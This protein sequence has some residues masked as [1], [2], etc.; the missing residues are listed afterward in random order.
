MIAAEYFG[1]DR[2]ISA[3]NGRKPALTS[4]LGDRGI[5]DIGRAELAA[6]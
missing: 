2:V 1:S 6:G 4:R 3:I 5:G